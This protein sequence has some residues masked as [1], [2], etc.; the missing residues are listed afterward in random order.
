MLLLP[1]KTGLRVSQNIFLMIFTFQVKAMEVST[2]LTLLG[3]FI[4]GTKGNT[5]THP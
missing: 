2:F 1:Y 5:S 4:S 3:N